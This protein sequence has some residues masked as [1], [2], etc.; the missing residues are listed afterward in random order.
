MIFGKRVFSMSA[1]GLL[2]CLL[3][4]VLFGCTPTPNE[5]PQI[6]TGTFHKTYGLYEQINV[7][8]NV[9]CDLYYEIQNGQ[10]WSTFG[11]RDV[12]SWRTYKLE[13]REDGAFS[14]DI[15]TEIKDGYEG[16]T[17]PETSPYSLCNRSLSCNIV[18]LENEPFSFRSAYKVR[19]LDG[20]EESFPDYFYLWVVDGM[21][22]EHETEFK[23]HH[24]RTWWMRLYV[25][26]EDSPTRLTMY[27][28]AFHSQYFCS[29]D[30]NGNEIF[31]GEMDEWIHDRF[32]SQNYAQIMS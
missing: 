20:S 8:E 14:F 26:F 4:L 16:V 24:N 28:Y 19:D 5:E 3:V 21:T 18:G 25:V 32:V 15:S 22:L 23:S 10:S 30:A 27:E 7:V 29:H 9:E 17:P 12:D 6:Q 13:E 11:T 2:C 31:E 1:L